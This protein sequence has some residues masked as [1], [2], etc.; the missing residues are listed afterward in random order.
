M[1]QQCSLTD[2]GNLL[3]DV[4]IR[5]PLRTPIGRCRGHLK[6]DIGPRVGR[7]G[8]AGPCWTAPTSHQNALDDVVHWD[9]Y[10]SSE[11]VPRSVEWWPWT[12]VCR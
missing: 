5:E 8:A 12:R 1:V 10:P 3:R 4:V 9:S 6:V 2:E 7:H 11:S